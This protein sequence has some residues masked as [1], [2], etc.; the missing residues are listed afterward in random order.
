MANMI[1]IGLPFVAAILFTM[2]ALVAGSIHKPINEIRN[3][4]HEVEK[5]NL[6]VHVGI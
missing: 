3:A 2:T 6:N 1:R 4:T 5:G